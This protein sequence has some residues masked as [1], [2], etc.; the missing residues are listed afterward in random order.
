MSKVLVPF[1]FTAEQLP[2][3]SV[4]PAFKVP[5]LTVVVPVYVFVFANIWTPVPVLTILPLVP[6]IVPAYVAGAALSAQP[7]LNVFDPKVT[8]PFVPG[9]VKD[10]IAL[11]N[12][13]MSN[14]AEAALAIVTAEQLPKA[15]V[16]PAFNV[17]MDTVVG[18]V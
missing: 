5:S 13:V 12:P 9:A 17:P 15:V 16:L 11:S 2:N 10:P 6:V 14:V 18:P 3:A 1:K 4:A 8:V 7:M